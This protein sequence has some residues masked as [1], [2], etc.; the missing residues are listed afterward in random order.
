MEVIPIALIPDGLT[1]IPTT[2]DPLSNETSPVTFTTESSASSTTYATD[3]MGSA[4]YSSADGSG[5][6]FPYPL[7]III[8]AWILLI[9]A[10][11]LCRW[12]QKT[13]ATY[14]IPRVFVLCSPRTVQF[15]YELILRIGLPSSDFNPDRHDIDLTVQGQQ[16]NEVVPMTRLNTR[17]LLDEQLITSLS[18]IVYRLV[19]MPSLGGLILKHSGPFKA[20]VYA[21]DF[22]VIDLSN[23]RELYYTLNQYIGSLDREIPLAEPNSNNSVYY[24]IDDVPLP[25]WSIEDIFLILYLLVNFTMLSITLMPINCSYVHDI[26]A[27]AITAFGGGVLVAFMNW[28]LHYNLSWNQDRREYFNEYESCKFCPNENIIRTII[29]VVAT[30][31]G[32]LSVYYGLFINDLR[33][34]VVLLLA[35]INT[36]TLV[37]GIWNGARLAN[38]GESIV[39]LGL[40]L[41][42]TTMTSVGM[43]YSEMLSDVQTK[44]ASASDDGGSAL[45]STKTGRGFGPQT[46]VKS[47]G[48]E[49]IGASKA[50]KLASKFYNSRISSTGATPNNQPSSRIFHSPLINLPRAPKLETAKLN[51]PKIDAPKQDPQKSEHPKSDRS[52]PEHSK[53]NHSK[54]DHS[55]PGHQKPEHPRLELSKVEHTKPDHPKVDHSRP[56]HPKSDP[57]KPEPPKIDLQRLEYSK[58]DRPKLDASKQDHQRAEL[59]KPEPSKTDTLRPEHAKTDRLRFDASRSEPHRVDSQ[60]IEHLKLDR[61]KIATAKPDSSKPDPQVLDHSKPDHTGLETLKVAPLKPEVAKPDH[62]K[63]DFA[64]SERSKTTRS[65]Y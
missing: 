11:L 5:F 65:L 60:K 33:D 17:T 61:P 36:C 16:K 52:K 44:S 54:S 29:A 28:L 3:N 12:Q 53:L 20:W 57:P 15:H 45:A 21:Y 8:S 31:I 55:K 1:T 38:V 59:V 46:S 7:A 18:I 30:I 48:F 63:P 64:T 9:L 6:R 2:N 42:G 22:T 51:L 13:K 24:P 50:Q 40:R 49:L 41:R 37:I 10:Y 19:E 47:F 25:Q 34:S 4:A 32:A 27:I 43:R 58:Q 62:S 23:N 26:I 14:I 39:D 56:D 35:V